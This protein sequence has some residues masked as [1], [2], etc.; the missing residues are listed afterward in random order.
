MPN[1]TMQ[2]LPAVAHPATA[3][4]LI[5]ADSDSAYAEHLAAGRVY[6]ADETVTRRRVVRTRQ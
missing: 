4:E 6:T 3:S 2:V 1:V 5:I